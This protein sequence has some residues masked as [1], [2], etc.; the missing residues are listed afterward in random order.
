MPAG[1]QG[2]VAC[3]SHVQGGLGVGRGWV[4]GEGAGSR[5]GGQG[6]RGPAVCVYD[7]VTS[8]ARPRGHV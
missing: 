5:E 3:P 1:S 7:M 8:P 2:K 6:S 4:K